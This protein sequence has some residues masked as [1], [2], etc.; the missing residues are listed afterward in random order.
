MNDDPKPTRARPRKLIIEIEYHF[1]ARGRR[2]G[3][4]EEIR[5]AV[6]VSIV[7]RLQGKGPITVDSVKI[8]EL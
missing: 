2:V 3:L 4:R 7:R 8:K 1:H 6:M 5:E